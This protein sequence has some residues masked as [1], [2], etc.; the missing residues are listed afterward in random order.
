MFQLYISGKIGRIYNK[1]SSFRGEH[2]SSDRYTLEYMQKNDKK[3]D[4]QHM[5]Q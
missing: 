4:L 3:K 2:N 5:D 1:I